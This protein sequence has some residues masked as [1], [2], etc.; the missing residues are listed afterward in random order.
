LAVVGSNI[1]NAIDPEMGE[2]LPQ[3]EPLV[4]LMKARFGPDEHSSGRSLE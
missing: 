1:E 2:E 4:R 3:M